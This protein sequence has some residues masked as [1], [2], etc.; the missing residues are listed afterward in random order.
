MTDLHVYINPKT[1]KNAAM[2]SPEI[3]KIMMDNGDKLN[4][5]IIYD[6]DYNY[7]YFGFKVGCFPSTK[8]LKMQNAKF[9]AYS[10]HL[11]AVLTTSF[12]KESRDL[13]AFPP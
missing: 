5:A 3:Y 10:C 11:I 9:T 8:L 2:V 12:R 4:S 13:L 7:N 6:R 1:G